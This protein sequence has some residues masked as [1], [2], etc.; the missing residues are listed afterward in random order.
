[1]K[2]KIVAVGF[3]LAGYLATASARPKPSPP[4]APRFVEM[5]IIF[6]RAKSIVGT[7]ATTRLC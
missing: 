6:T 2:R 5:P 1:M 7:R 3:L 4:P